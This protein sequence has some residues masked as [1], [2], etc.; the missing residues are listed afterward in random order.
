MTQIQFWENFPKPDNHNVQTDGH[1]KV[2]ESNLFKL[3]K[4][5][6]T[7]DPVALFTNGGRLREYDKSISRQCREMS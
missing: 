2:Q 4:D 3:Q 6:L 5:P 1:V 7:F